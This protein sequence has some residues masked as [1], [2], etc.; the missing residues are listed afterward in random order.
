MDILF[1]NIFLIF[2]SLISIVGVVALFFF[3]V[4]YFKIRKKRTVI[5]DIYPRLKKLPRNPV[6]SPVPYLA[7]SQGGTFNPAAFKGKDGRTHI[8]YRAVGNDGVSRLAYAASDDGIHFNDQVPYP[9]FS[10]ESLRNIPAY[11]KKPNFVM[12]PS[13]GSWGG[14]EDPRMVLID[15]TIYITFSAFDGWDFIRMGVISIKEEDLLKKHWYWNRPLLISP[16]GKVNKNW[17]LFP[18]KI[19]G[20]FAILHSI[21][22]KV[23]I[24]YVESFERLARGQQIIDSHFSNGMPR[25]TWDTWVRGVGPPPIR[26]DYGWLVLYHGV[27]KDEPHKYKLGAIL[28]DIN[29]PHKIIARSPTP[30]LDPDM[31]YESDW[32][33]G[34]IYA[35]GAVIENDTLYVYYGGGDKHV[36]VAH[37]PAHTLLNWLK[38]YGH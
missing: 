29:D 5:Q 22:P 7:W 26:T 34:V 36:C 4:R 14:C 25:P 31:W 28:L 12:Y 9:V 8:I 16:P 32:K 23:E 17:V 10:M 3:V 18:E 6:I 11:N 2:I 24:D 27:S 30:I 19:N 38:D 33:P 13:G 1:I 20:K 37:M 21:S 15:G 35:C